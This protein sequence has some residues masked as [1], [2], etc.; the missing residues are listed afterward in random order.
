MPQEYF[1]GTRTI[2]HDDGS[3]THIT[4]EHEP[5]VEPLTPK[6]TVALAGIVLGGLAVITSV[7]FISEWLEERR[8]TKEAERRM[9]LVK[10]DENPKNDD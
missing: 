5:Y 6:Q 9:K 1:E 8:R 10:D 3:S 7:P 2:V 4:Y